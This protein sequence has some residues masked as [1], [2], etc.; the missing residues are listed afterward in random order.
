M[1]AAKQGMEC[2]E[3]LTIV[4]HYHVT[5]HRL[6]LHHTVNGQPCTAGSRCGFGFISL[7]Y[8][9]GPQLEKLDG[10]GGCEIEFLWLIPITK[11]ELKY[12]KKAGA[13]ALEVKF[14]EAQF[15]Y[16]DPFRT[17]VV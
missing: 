4:A 12:K 15:N 10:K 17:D 11:E 7:P 3:L 5:A 8:L 13:E 6:D 9:E 1:Y 14:E 16:T 2:V